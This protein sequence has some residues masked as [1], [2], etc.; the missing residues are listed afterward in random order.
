MADEVQ[1]VS[2]HPRQHMKWAFVA[3]QSPVSMPTSTKNPR[4]AFLIT[5]DGRRAAILGSDMNI[6]PLQCLT[7][8]LSASSPTIRSDR[9]PAKSGFVRMPSACAVVSSTLPSIRESIGATW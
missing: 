2:K 7:A 5:K 6:L 1:G 3:H 8:S 4:Y 9:S